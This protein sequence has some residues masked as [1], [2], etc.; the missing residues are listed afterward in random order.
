M[1][2]KP[3]RL[4]MKDGTPY[5]VQPCVEQGTAHTAEFLKTQIASALEKLSVQS[6]WQRFASPMARLTDAQLDYLTRLDGKDRVAW[7]ATVERDGDEHGIGLARYV[8]LAH[9]PG[10][11]EFAVTVVDEYQAQGIGYALMTKLKE[12]ARENG[13]TTLRGYVLPSNRRMLALCRRLGAGLGTPESGFITAEIAL[14]GPT[15]PPVEP[16]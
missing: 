2:S 3:A 7:C 8:R 15:N 5:S 1:H 10:V 14:D 13:L 11:A 16:V 4:A 6:R 9:D 12:T